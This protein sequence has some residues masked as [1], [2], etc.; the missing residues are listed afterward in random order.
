MQRS[1]TVFVFLLLLVSGAE[2]RTDFQ[3]SSASAS[4]L[5]VIDGDTIRVN[6]GGT[7]ETV[8]LLFVDTM[9]TR[10]N[11]KLKRDVTYWRK[12]GS[13]LSEKELL[14]MG[15][16]AARALKTE[17]PCGATVRLSWMENHKRD[18]YGRLLA[19][20]WKNGMNQN[21]WLVQK[22]WA[23]SYFVGSTPP[24]WKKAI[25]EA[26]QTAKS[27]RLGIWKSIVR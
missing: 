8:R 21:L 10:R 19:L 4:V 6:L 20:V 16:N 2:A 9:E 18:R 23:R 7:R 11:S 1:L 3:Y 24:E 22:G 26:E 17:L 13:P 12:S 25:L 15:R 27:K 14:W 5:E